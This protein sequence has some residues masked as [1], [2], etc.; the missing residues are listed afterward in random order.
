MEPPSTTNPPAG[1][2]YAPPATPVEANPYAAPESTALVAAERKVYT[3][4]H[5]VCGTFFASLFCTAWMIR[6]NYK[7]FGKDIQATKAFWLVSAAAL[8]LMIISMVLPGWFWGI[9]FSLISLFIVSNWF[10]SHMQRDFNTYIRKKGR[11][12]SHWWAF[13]VIL[14]TFFMVF[15]FAIA[16]GASCELMGIDL[17]E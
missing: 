15:A 2:P 4:G 1:Q 13:G 12:H 16:I 8:I 11:R 17:P 6:N 10:T 5:M 14:L 9:I 3:L 7:A